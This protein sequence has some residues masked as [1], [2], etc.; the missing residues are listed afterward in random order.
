[1]D[2]DPTVRADIVSAALSIVRENGVFALNLTEVLSRTGL[3][4]RAFYRH[5]DS[6]NHLTQAVFL[7]LARSESLRLRTRMAGATDPVEAVARWIDARLE[8]AFDTPDTSELRHFSLEAQSQM[9]ATPDKVSAAFT[10]MLLPL[11]EEL[12]RGRDAGVFHDI[13]PVGEA[14]SIHG[15]VWVCTQRHWVTGDRLSGHVRRQTTQF[16]LRGLGVAPEA[17][18]SCLND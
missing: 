3:S 2:P 1:L 4:T 10:E 18:T 6:M 7:D 17:I 9:F 5:F 16:C 15:V 14:E 13:D 12:E 8:L 11:V